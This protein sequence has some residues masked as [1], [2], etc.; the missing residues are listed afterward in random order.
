MFSIWVHMC[1]RFRVA[2]TVVTCSY[3]GPLRIY[4]WVVLK[5]QERPQSHMGNS[6]LEFKVDDIIKTLGPNFYIY[7]RSSKMLFYSSFCYNIDKKKKERKEKQFPAQATVCVQFACSSHVC[8]VVGLWFV[9]FFW[10]G[11]DFSFL[12]HPKSVPSRG[13]G[14]STLCPSERVWVCVWVCPV[15][16]GRPVQGG[17]LPCTLSCWDR[18]HPPKTLNWNKQAGE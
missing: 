8:M 11:G 13:S 1:Y 16:E 4:V 10:G 2:L 3:S 9:C 5:S 14:L 12:P 18:P 17:C 7:N 15:M 6:N